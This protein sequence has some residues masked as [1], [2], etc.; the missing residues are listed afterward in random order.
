[1]QA[2][3]VEAAQA[4]R[5]FGWN[6]T[7][8]TSH[9][10]GT[11]GLRPAV[12]A[13]YA[14]AFHVQPEWLLYERGRS[15]P[16]P[17]PPVQSPGH[18]PLVGWVAAGAQ[19]YFF[20]DQGDLGRIRAPAATPETVAVEIRGD[21]LGSFFNGWVAFYDDVRRPVTTDLI[22]KLCIVGLDDGGIY[23]KK[24]Q[25]SR[26]RGLFHLFS[27]ADEAPILDVAI[28]WAARVKHL[29]PR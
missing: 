9:E 16:R 2:G 14:K 20:Q 6:E 28:E 22:G 12:A 13:R 27:Q 3:F 5:A 7:T 1:M 17:A 25:R 10:N 18:V 15:N 11:R 8:Y 4:A 21:S 26:A 23:V 19:A 29:A 24:I